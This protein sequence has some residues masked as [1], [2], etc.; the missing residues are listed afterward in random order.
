MIGDRFKKLLRFICVIGLFL[1]LDARVVCQAQA[2]NGQIVGSV[3]DP[4]EAAIKGAAITVYNIETGSS[5]TLD[6]DESG[7]F[8]FLLLPLGS[9]RIIVRA[10][11]FSELVREGVTL[12]AGQTATL[13][14]SLNAGDVRE[15]VTITSDV[16]VVDTAKVEQGRVMNSRE[17]ASLPL[18]TLNPYTFVFLQ[19]NV[20][21]N[22]TAIPGLGVVNV[23]AN[24]FSRRGNYQLDG[25]HATDIN[26]GGGR[27]MLLARPFIQEIQ[28]LTSGMNAEF[29]ATAGHVM[30]AVTRAGTNVLG[31]TVSYQFR[32]RGFAAQRFNVAPGAVN[33]QPTADVFTA[34]VGGPVIK[35][36][37]QFF[38]GFEAFKWDLASAARVI[39]VTPANRQALVAAGVPESAMPASYPAPE[40][41]RFYIGRSDLQLNPSHRLA[42]RYLLTEGISERIGVAAL[43]LGT[44]QISRDNYVLENSVGFQLVSK[45][46]ERIFNELR[47]QRSGRDG[48]SQPST[49]TGQGE[50][51]IRIDGVASFGAPPNSFSN[52]EDRSLAT[53]QNN[54][55]LLLSSHAIKIGGG[56]GIY[57][58]FQP[59]DPSAQYRFATLADYLMAT[60][61]VDRLS[62]LRY[63][64]TFGDPSVRIGTIFSNAFIQ[65]E[66]RVTRSLLI[67]LGVR[68]DLFLPPDGKENSLY[69]GARDFNTD[70]DN[71]GPRLGF[72][73]EALTGMRPGVVRASVGLYFDPLILNYYRRSL[74]N[75]GDQSTSAFTLSNRDGPEFPARFGA[76]PSHVIA[77]L[78]DI[79]AI[80]EDFRTMSALHVNVQYEQTL[81]RDLSVTAAYSHSSGRHI[82]ISRQVNCRPAG[83]KLADGRPLYGRIT[84]RT[85]GT[86]EIVPCIDR[87]SPQ[88]NNVL[89]RESVG[90]LRYDA[91]TISLAKRFSSGF[92][93]SLSYT[94][95]HSTDDAPEENIGVT[96]QIISDP[97]NRRRDRAV[98]ISN[99]KHTLAGTLVVRP[100][101]ENTGP[102]TALFL[103]NNQLAFI[104]RASSGELYNLRTN[105]DLNHDGVFMDRPVNIARNSLKTPV[106]F[107]LDV[108]YSRF[109]RFSRGRAFE[110][111]A[112]ISN[113]TNTNSIVGFA[114]TILS[115]NNAFTSLVDPV[116]GSLRGP[117][118]DP[119][120]G[121]V[122]S[123]D[124]R[125]IQ[126]GLKL[127]I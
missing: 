35:Y 110:L 12:A 88:F 122:I 67:N 49:E 106:F 37:W 123:N 126:L 100:S 53:I 90:N 40:E 71:Y 108:R 86:F 22:R 46:G 55:S 85:N 89:R 124:S 87:I 73:Y 23:N 17:V 16:P 42:L 77:P 99:Q 15:H 118:P 79:E 8:R 3:R 61:G 111:F 62:Y 36:R 66:W 75:N 11:G 60:S 80:S 102:L 127:S 7:S 63:T 58:S 70:W 93:A 98:S 59:S 95:S 112:D 104:V 5:R 97:S 101:F 81:M 121:G 19:S 51:T 24:G 48:T 41:Y 30:N 6:S 64:D 18:I 50:V 4:N 33:Y 27:I 116:T 120:L 103:N 82:P 52:F 2:V 78:P 25:N 13:D 34:T 31:G 65:D 45:K 114:N 109:F 117:I 125:R 21:G 76:L 47:F 14:V 96:A 92:Q 56:V 83:G 119:A 94:Q 20:T 84:V 29:G 91:A 9:Y 28:L 44:L 32:R 38:A 72:A 43:P 54:L 107:N 10:E 115:V 113:L 68:Y 57:R 69:P 74:Q 26:F 1:I 39:N 105:V